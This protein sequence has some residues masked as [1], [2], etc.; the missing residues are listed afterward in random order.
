MLAP[1]P[2]CISRIT[3][4]YQAL[5]MKKTDA[6]VNVLTDSTPTSLLISISLSQQLDSHEHSSNGQALRLGKAYALENL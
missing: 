5:R 6:R 2:A 4:K 3:R 1:I